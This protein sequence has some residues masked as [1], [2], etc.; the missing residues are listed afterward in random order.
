MTYLQLEKTNGSVPDSVL[1]KLAGDGARFSSAS[2]FVFL[3]FSFP[4]LASDVLAASGIQY[5]HIVHILCQ[6][7]S[8]NTSISKL[9]FLEGNY[10]FAAV[11]GQEKYSYL[12]A[13]FAPVWRDVNELLRNP[14]V[15]I[16][17]PSIS[18]VIKLQIV[19]G[20]DYK[21]IHTCISMCMCEYI[22]AHAHCSSF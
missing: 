7:S 10:T 13:A 2:N 1:V 11:K 15:C 20:A 9:C 17:T 18:H 6:K 8:V 16:D 21:V 19:L 12:G 22:H 3:T 4:S 14:Y 5:I